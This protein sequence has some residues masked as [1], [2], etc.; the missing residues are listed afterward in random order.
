MSAATGNIYETCILPFIRTAE[1]GDEILFCTPS[2]FFGFYSLG[3]RNFEIVCDELRAAKR[4]RVKLRLLVDVHDPMAAKATE[5]LLTFLKDDAEIRHL[6]KNTD[7]YSILLYRPDGGSRYA[8]FASE[9]EREVRYL[10]SVTIRKFHKTMVES[11]PSSHEAES[12]RRAFLQLWDN[13]A[14]K[15]VEERLYPYYALN[16]AWHRNDQLLTTTWI[17]CFGLGLAC[18]WLS[19]VTLF[20]EYPKLSWVINSAGSFLVGFFANLFTDAIKRHMGRVR[21]H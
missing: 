16:N 9:P 4:R 18:G 10:P 1:K 17:L 21:R 11:T 19:T 12:L 20:R 15:P 5:G 6:E 14:A 13:P 2:V 7:N 3:A 8:S